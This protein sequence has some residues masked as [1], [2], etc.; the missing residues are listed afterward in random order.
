MTFSWENNFWYLNYFWYLMWKTPQALYLLFLEP[1]KP[2]K[3]P[4]SNSRLMYQ[5]PNMYNFQEKRICANACKGICAVTPSAASGELMWKAIK[6]AQI[7]FYLNSQKIYLSFYK[8]IQLL[9]LICLLI[10]WILNLSVNI[11][12]SPMRL[13]ISSSKLEYDLF[14]L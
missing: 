14:I 8:N 4:L 6:L 2:G 12:I 5:G 3:R 10:D 13:N 11:W 1:D 7:L 9:H